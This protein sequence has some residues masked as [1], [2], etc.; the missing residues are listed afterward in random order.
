MLQLHHGIMHKVGADQ[1]F[2]SLAWGEL[3]QQRCDGSKAEIGLRNE[4]L[5][6]LVLC[7]FVVVGCDVM[8]QLLSL[9]AN[10]KKTSGGDLFTY[11]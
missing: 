1:K 11:Q 6:Q 7:L 5:S 10:T 4:V 9:E 3:V 8:C 2:G